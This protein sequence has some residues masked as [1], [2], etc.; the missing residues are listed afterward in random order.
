MQRNSMFPLCLQQ[1]P[2]S[3]PAFYEYLPHYRSQLFQT[4]FNS[5]QD[6]LLKFFLYFAPSTFK[7]VFPKNKIKQK[8][9][10]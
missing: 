1:I 7:V 9:V 6:E 2:L 8:S 10:N 4:S 5:V 3:L